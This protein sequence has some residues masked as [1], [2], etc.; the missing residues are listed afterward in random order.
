MWFHQHLCQG[1]HPDIRFKIHRD[2]TTI[3][4]DLNSSVFL[5]HHSDFRRITCHAFIHRIVQHFQQNVMKTMQIVIANIHTR[6]LTYS[7]QEFK[8]NNMI[9]TVLLT[10]TILLHSTRIKRV[11][12][13]R[14]FVLYYITHYYI[15]Q[16]T[17]CV[18]IAN[19]S[20]ILPLRSM[21]A[22]VSQRFKLKIVSSPNP[23]ELHHLTSPRL[24][25]GL[26]LALLLKNYWSYPASQRAP[27]P[28]LYGTG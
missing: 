3:V 15:L 27:N 5:N 26:I 18:K 6:P 22:I 23:G 11:R 25:P 17:P 4:S 19:D 16:L 13:F 21:H 12:L 28:P 20:L 8:F 1:T 9:S 7:I 2:T 24:H 14:T 10:H